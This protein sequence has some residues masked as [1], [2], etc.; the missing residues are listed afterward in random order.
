MSAGTHA[1]GSVIK[2]TGKLIK[3]LVILAVA[4]VAVFVIVALVGLG[5]ASN[6]SEKS[7]KQVDPAA[8]SALAI[9][10]QASTVRAIFGKPERTQVMQVSGEPTSTCWYYGILAQSGTYQLC[11]QNSR[12]YTKAR[13]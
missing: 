1:A 7:A 5:N 12:L 9:G 6:N 11:F 8:F 3:W 4:V 13:Y 2:G 10:A